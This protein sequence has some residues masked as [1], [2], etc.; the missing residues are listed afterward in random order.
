MLKRRKL[1]HLSDI[2]LQKLLNTELWI[3]NKSPW[4]LS[5]ELGVSSVTIKTW[6]EYFKIP[7]RSSSESALVRYST[8]SSEELRATTAHMTEI[9]RDPERMRARGVKM[10]K[11]RQITRTM[12]KWEVWFDK[13]LIEANITGFVHEYAIGIYNADFAFPKQKIT[14]EVDTTRHQKEPKRTKDAEK[15]AYTASQGWTTLRVTVCKEQYNREDTYENPIAY[16]R[17]A[18]KA[19]E[20]LKVL[21]ERGVES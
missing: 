3:N 13:W 14:V 2:E 4:A 17:N 15:D 18:L 19:I 5:S 8:Y 16:K 9:L 20:L 11:T 6:C 12:S 1:L 10:A 21:L 7:V